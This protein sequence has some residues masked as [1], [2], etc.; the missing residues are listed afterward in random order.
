M[1]KLKKIFKHDK[2]DSSSS[3]TTPSH[4]TS[5]RSTPATTTSSAPAPQT[6]TSSTPAA[7]ATANTTA[8]VSKG[9]PAGVLLETNYGNITIAL[10]S[11]KTPKTCENFAGLADAGKYNGVI[12]H[13]IIPGFMLQ[14][15][16]PT[17]TGRGGES[18]WGGKFADEFDS[19]LKH[20][21]AGVLSMANSGPGT[22]GSQFFICLAPTPHLNGKHTV[23]GQVV[24]GLDVVQKIGAVRTGAG[25]RPIEDVVIVKAQS[26]SA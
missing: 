22:N 24:D 15:G 8:P 19:S 7:A 12:F 3:T 9:P 17:G 10:Y 18:I 13:R 20:T 6:T 21:G 11:D 5:E 25:D 23:F 14:G 1:D 16:D 4:T 2:S 26:F